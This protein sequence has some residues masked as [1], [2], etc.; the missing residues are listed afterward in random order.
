MSNPDNSK[1][2]IDS[3]VISTPV[4]IF[5]L[6][7]TIILF[8]FQGSIKQFH[9]F[10]WVGLPLFTYIVCSCVNMIVQYMSCKKVDAGRAFLGGLPSFGTVLL[11]LGI[12]SISYCRIP[13]ASV[14]APLII[15]KDVDVTKKNSSA[16]ASAV[17][18]N[19]LKN[20]NLKECCTPKMT[21]D[22]VETR[23]PIVA[24]IAYGF[25]VM[26]GTLFGLTLGNGIASIC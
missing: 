18:I 20:S 8:I 21:L 13:I 6:S 7:I 2:N 9:L 11:A 24:G 12:A 5:F 14:F 3:F 15:G 17:N 22:T 16:N 23:Y 1:L 25:Y 10:L 19:S 26:F 4:A